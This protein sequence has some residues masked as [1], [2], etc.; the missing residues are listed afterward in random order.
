MRFK[1]QDV[2]SSTIRA[3]GYRE[4]TQE[5]VVKFHNGSD[6]VYSGVPPET[7]EEFLHAGSKG[8]YLHQH[9]KPVYSFEKL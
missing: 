5:L 7:W 4:K 9:I 8:Q 6:Y 2:D 3:I 1:M